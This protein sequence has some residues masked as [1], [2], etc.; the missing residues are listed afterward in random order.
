MAVMLGASQPMFVVWGSGRTL[1]YNDGYSEILASKH[2]AAIGRDF[3]EV[4]DEIRDDLVPIV[5]QAF[6]GDPVQMDDIELWMNRRGFRE[7]AHFAFSY[8]P[9]RAEDGDIAGFFCALQEITG[10]VLAQRKLR[11]S[12]ARAHADA[13][14]V[15]LALAAGAIIGTWFYDIQQDQFAVDEQFAKAFGIDPQAGREGLNL[16]QMM[17]TIHPEDKAGV[18]AAVEEAIA[19]GGSY[20][21]QYRVR[22]T[23]GH[24]YWI[25]A[26]GRV[27][28]AD[29]GTPLRFP[30]VLLDIEER[31]AVEA[32]R[33]RAT[34][35]LRT[36]ADAVPGVVYAKDRQGRMLVANRGTTELI[37][38]P[39]ELYIG[40]TDAE[41]LDDEAQAAAVMANDE[42]VMA[43]GIAEQIEEE[44]TFPD[45][46]R[47][48]W[49]STKAPLRDTAGEVV[50]L[51]GSSIDITAR[52]QA[53]A[54]LAD[55][56]ERFRFALDAAGGIGT[57]DWDVAADR[58]YTSAR[59]AKMYGLDPERATAGLSVND[60]LDGI[61]PD[62]REAVGRLIDEAMEGGSEFRAEYRLIGRDG[63]ARWVIA[64]GRCLTGDDGRPVRFPGVTFDISDRRKAEETLRE[65][66]ERYRLAAQATND[67]IWDWRMADGHVI[68]NEALRTLFGH[69]FTET[70]AEWWL[71]HIHPADRERVDRE[72][73]AVIDGEGTV[74]MAEYRFRRAD[75]TYAEVLDRGHVLRGADGR[76]VRMIGAMLDLTERRAAEAARAESEERLRLAT[77]AAEV[78]F[79]DVDVVNDVLIWPPRVKAMFGISSDVPVSMDDFYLGMH[80]D[81]REAT[82]SA[83]AA[84]CDPALRA[85]YDVEYRT[86]GKEDGIVR[87]VA[88]K[89]RGLF[90]N[91]GRCTRV[92]GTAVD[93]TD[94]KRVEAELRELNERL[95]SRVA[96]EIAERSKAEEALRQAQ[97]MEA[98]GQL[99]GGIAHDFNNLLTVVTGNI[100]MAGRALEAAGSLDP[101]ARRAL[102]NAMKGAERA[103][104]L[105]QRLLAFSRR[106]PLAPKPLDVDKLVLSMS[107]MLNR[108]LGEMVKLEI[109]TSPGLW[110]I[111]A[112]PNQL[113]SAIL[114]LAVNARDAMPQGGDLTIETANA[115]LDDSYVAHH[116]EVAPGQ[117]VVIAV[118]D[119]GVGM[120]KDV[121]SRVFEPFYTTK[122]VG[123]G[124]GLG[125]SM[126]YGFVKQSGGH[127]KIYTEE[128]HGTTVK[129]YL[130]RLMS[131]DAADDEATLT[132]GLEVSR[133][134]E[135]ILVVEDDDDVRAY[136]VECLRE[137]GYRVIE[138]HDGPSALRLLERQEEP[139]DLLFTDVVMP[140]MSGRELADAAR[141]RQPSLKVVYTSGYTRNAIVHGGRLDPGV[142][143]IAK[144]F[145]YQALAQKVRDV[146]DRGK[147]GRVIVAEADATVRAL[148]GEALAMSGYTVDEAANTTELLTKIRSAQGGFD[149]V[150]LDYSLP[151]R[152][153]DGLVAEL[154]AIHADLPLLIASAGEL[155]ELRARFALDRCIG[156]VERPYTS[157]KLQ[158]ALQSLGVSCSPRRTGR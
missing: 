125:L 86:I 41:F 30:G 109:V 66:E 74:W 2:P 122:E 36:F 56:E 90:D 51:V 68:W 98:V 67:A 50:G 127:V 22:R 147:T 138:A 58:V 62:D 142:D 4:W 7:E 130:P 114:N 29:D 65:T 49:L 84:A 72:I 11:E 156:F 119:N 153:G 24:Y 118:T 63:E 60:Y 79:W 121:A 131:D 87:W 44:V 129:I 3:L 154:R 45:G 1:L 28:R 70:R 71:E 8:T 117:Y 128:G 110:R 40:R 23:D 97:K 10:Q 137:L 126:V 27:E 134:R 77:E 21:H 82:G 78:G 106:Q 14:R 145:T 32:E 135:T 133:D 140:G 144:P 81:D 157:A 150:V 15:K 113:E 92:I 158:K 52:K 99:T 88:A 26:N 57:W 146:L 43:S 95:E 148:A 5:D 116:A 139:L 83:F 100:D 53:E 55:N 101:R 61:H 31:R 120:S 105:T 85:L 96:E 37:G 115:R 136:T 103:A 19:R 108:A 102:D 38:K 34:E 111:E 64:R 48:I 149:A 17:A 132:P 39:P 94:R 93:V 155:E 104:S 91:G 89:G 9:V 13:E 112:D 33:D 16:E 151:D 42:R 143:L 124:T 20:A 80:P 6:G 69:R 25:E 73:H 54:K 76:A 107:D 12:E 35:L 152:T 47:A 123:K 141:E 59:F 75:G 18:L 46:R